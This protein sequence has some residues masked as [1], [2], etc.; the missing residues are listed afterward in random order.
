MNGKVIRL[1]RKNG[2]L[3]FRCAGGNEVLRFEPNGNAYV[4]GELVD[5]NKE[6]YVA[7]RQWL[8]MVIPGTLL[9]SIPKDQLSVEE[10]KEE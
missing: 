1:P 6:V 3:T 9:K 2:H 4:R 7:L 5:S 8:N 10:K